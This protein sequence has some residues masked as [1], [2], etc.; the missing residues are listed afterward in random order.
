MDISDKASAAIA[1]SFDFE[2][3]VEKARHDYP[4]LVS[5]VVFI[6]LARPDARQQVLDAVAG[7]EPPPTPEHVKDFLREFDTRTR[8]DGFVNNC[9]GIPF[10]FAT[11][12]PHVGDFAKNNPGKAAAYA[13]THELGHLVVQG[14]RVSRQGNPAEALFAENFSENIA[15][16]FAIL[17]GLAEGWLNKDDVARISLERV[18]NGWISQ[19]FDHITTLALDN[20]ILRAEDIVSL[21]ATPAEIA[22][23]THAHATEF[24]L[25][26]GSMRYIFNGLASLSPKNRL[27][28]LESQQSMMFESIDAQEDMLRETVR[29]FQDHAKILADACLE[30]PADSAAFHLYGRIIAQTLR[31]GKIEGITIDLSDPFWDKARKD[32]VEKSYAAGLGDIFKVEH[33]DAPKPAE[34]RHIDTQRRNHFKNK[35]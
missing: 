33:P 34:S 14:G 11:S 31:T 4:E 29:L 10:L 6:D 22:A 32:L 8:S 17:T 13:F 35:T 26:P 23:I 9:N 27:L 25:A 1:P 24:T 19:D 30:E 7:I 5:N 21:S 12:R 2:K 15:D 20:I 18:M 3:S 16:S 28:G